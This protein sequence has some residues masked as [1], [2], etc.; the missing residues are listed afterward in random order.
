MSAE[1]AVKDADFD[2]LVTQIAG[3]IEFMLACEVRPNKDC[4]ICR[5]AAKK[6]IV[7]AGELGKLK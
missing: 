7:L 4:Q 5:S 1:A 3:L 2:A 6:A